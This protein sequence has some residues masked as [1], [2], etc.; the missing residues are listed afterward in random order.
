M[1][2][3]LKPA[4]TIAL[5]IAAAAH[6]SQ[7][8]A[9]S[10]P[11]PTGGDWDFR[12]E[13]FQALLEQK[14]LETVTTATVPMQSPERT[15]VI[16]VGKIDSITANYVQH[17]CSNGGAL[18]LACDSQRYLGSMCTFQSGAAVAQDESVTYQGYSDCMRITEITAEHPLVAGVG[19]LIVNR[20]GWISQPRWPKFTLNVAAKLP[21]NCRPSSAKNSPLLAT[22]D[23]FSKD[24]GRLVV[25]SDQSML[26][27]GMLWH[28]DNSLLAINLAD[29][30][31]SGQPRDRV[32]FLDGGRP[33]GS[34]RDSPL[35]DANANLPM[36]NPTD[37]PK[38]GLEQFLQL[39]NAVLKDVG[40]SN[41][42]NEALANHPR[43]VTPA[44]YRRAM[45]LVLAFL[46][47]AFVVWKLCGNAVSP[48]ESMPMRT[49]Q[50]AYAMQADRK[51]K[52]SEF[53]LA[54]NMLAR[55]LCRELTSSCDS[56]VW[57]RQL[58]PGVSSM[59]VPLKESSNQI[60]L[61]TVV[62]LAVNSQTVHISQKRFAAVGRT[63]QELRQLHKD[64]R[65]LDVPS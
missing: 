25:C 36:P 20:T 29:Y 41:I 40:Q 33:I 54:A 46:I 65:L 59:G 19:S 52:S 7:C 32:Y 49:M 17:F 63:I 53:G 43:G 9:Q 5:L 38:P 61:T 31:T 51:I 4:I 58:K 57:L 45:L 60:A 64:G 48:P 2:S 11:E 34:F 21:G 47:L 22:I 8:A 13:L 44:K 42:M 16:A 27:N 28:G 6:V 15:V 56:G 23:D 55:D 30:L 24:N 14:G 39:S 35:V 50:T 1:K 26:T 18:L 10:S 37:L 62:D 12:Y 3:L